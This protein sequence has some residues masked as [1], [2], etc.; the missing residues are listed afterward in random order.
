M[1]ENQIDFLRLLFGANDAE[2]ANDEPIFGDEN[3]VTRKNNKIYLGEGN[4]WMEIL[5][6]GMVHP[7]VFKACNL[8]NKEISGF[9]FGVGI[10]RLCMLKYGMPDLRDFFDND[11]RWLNHYGF[12]FFNYPDL[13]WE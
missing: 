8:E 4:D 9:A 13:N 5:G 6:C 1:G 2:N 11:L 3:I 7:N 10:E 12:S